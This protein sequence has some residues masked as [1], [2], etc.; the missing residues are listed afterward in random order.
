MFQTSP[1]KL[2]KYSFLLLLFLPGFINLNAQTT[3]PKVFKI[4]G[5]SVEGNKSADASTIIAN[6]G[7]KVGD[8]I[9]IPGDQSCLIAFIVWSPGI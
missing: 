8:E 4:L 6:S 2:F 3:Q 1:K 7:L 9:Q 5:I